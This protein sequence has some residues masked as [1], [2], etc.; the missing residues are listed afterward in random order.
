[1]TSVI[2]NADS[3]D[4]KISRQQGTELREAGSREKIKKQDEDSIG[5][6]VAVTALNNKNYKTALEIFL[7]RAK[8][9][10]A[11]SQ[12]QLGKM[13]QNGQG[14]VKDD[15]QAI[16]WYTQAAEQGHI[17][18]AF[19]L[20]WLYGNG[21]STVQDKA[22]SFKWYLKAALKGDAESQFLVGNL[23]D[24]GEGVAQNYERALF[25]Y[26]LV[27]EKRN[28]FA[29]NALG[30]LHQDGRGTLQDNSRAHMWYNIAGL[31]GSEQARKRRDMI[32]ARMN[33]QELERAQ[34]LARECVAR[35]YKRC[36]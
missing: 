25:W 1:M 16:Y 8:N 13:Y 18:A 12:F 14:V 2:A 11:S 3:L 17:D 5:Y 34:Q 26:T 24:N 19:N 10:A 33:S 32:S 7:G 27:A 9:G 22:Q 31:N 4:K 23:Y 36:Y 30:R 21:D 15:S 28:A 20:G 29:Q 35:N 6:Q